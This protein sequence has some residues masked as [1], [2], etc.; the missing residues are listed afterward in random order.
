M[1][2]SLVVD[3]VPTTLLTAAQTVGEMLSE[4]NVVVDEHDIGQPSAGT[5][6]MSESTV[7]VTHVGVWTET[8]RQPIA[9]PVKNVPSFRI[10]LGKT[11]VIDPGSD[12]V[13]VLSYIVSRNGD[14]AAPPRRSLYSTRVVRAARPRVI[15]HGVAEYALTQLAEQG[16]DAT[17]RFAGATMKMVATAY[18]ASCSGCSGRTKSG[19]PAGHGIVAVDPRVIPL[20]TAL[21][22]PGY[23]RAIAGDTGGAIRGNRID[24]G[25]N[26]TSDAFRF[27]TRP[28]TVYIL[29]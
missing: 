21:F 19:A 17:M 18:T 14:R 1:S 24:L 15:A 4:E 6:L 2:V 8:V 25:F 23:G 13:R 29:H 20:G 28:I 10:G 11:Q 7:R 5:L 16:F 27:G 12:G 3:G 26:S 9:A 22:I